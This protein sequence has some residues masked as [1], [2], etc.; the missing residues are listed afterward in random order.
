M[1]TKGRSSKRKVPADNSASGSNSGKKGR[2]VNNQLSINLSGHGY[3]LEHP[4]NKDDFKYILTEPDPHAPFRQDFNKSYESTGKV[5]P[6]WFFRALCPNQVLLALHDRA[7]Q[8]HI[9]DDRLSVTGEKG[10]CLVRATHSKLQVY[11]YLLLSTQKI[12]KTIFLFVN[13]GLFLIIKVFA[14]EIGIG[15]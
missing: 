1:L 7:P 6:S 4:F 12:N 8:L 9:S 2:T 5:I 11:N 15:K 14:V 10:Y 3:P 13:N